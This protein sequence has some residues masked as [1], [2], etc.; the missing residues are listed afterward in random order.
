M[1]YTLS[2]TIHKSLNE[3]IEKFTEPDG[4]M[5]WMEGL[6]KIERLSETPYKVGAKTNFHFLHRNKKMQIKDWI[7]FIVRR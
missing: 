1:K 4:A 2:N 6:Q 7:N 3:V 5:H